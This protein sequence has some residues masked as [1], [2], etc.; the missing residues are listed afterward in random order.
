MSDIPLDND[1]SEISQRLDR[2]CQL[3]FELVDRAGQHAVP[4]NFLL[5]L[6]KVI[7][8]LADRIKVETEREQTSREMQL[9]REEVESLEARVDTLNEERADL[10]RQVRILTDAKETYR[11]RALSLE[12]QLAAREYRNAYDQTNRFEY[13]RNWAFTDRELEGDIINNGMLARLCKPLTDLLKKEGKRSQR[14]K[15][16][17]AKNGA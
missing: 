1:I 15:R 9:L 17:A 14:R 10:K 11:Q 16:G 7:P 13:R 5:E 2:Y 12:G 3:D 4:L 6:K 8:P